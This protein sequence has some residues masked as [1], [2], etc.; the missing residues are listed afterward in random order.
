MLFFV[1][2]FYYFASVKKYVYLM[3]FLEILK[4]W[5][6]K[7]VIIFYNYLLKLQYS[8]LPYDYSYTRSIKIT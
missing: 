7:T 5:F 2:M 4:Y 3:M 1:E 8:I 6:Y